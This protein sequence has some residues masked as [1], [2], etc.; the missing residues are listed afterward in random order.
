MRNNGMTIIPAFSLGRTQ[1]LLYELNEV[2]KHENSRGCSL[3]K[4][5]D[6]TSILLS[7]HR[8]TE[9]YDSMRVLGRR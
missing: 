6:V 3:L 5:I 2:F 9:I 8:L 1:E 7:A 4:N